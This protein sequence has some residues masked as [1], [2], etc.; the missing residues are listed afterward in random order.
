[1]RALLLH[2]L[3]NF[4][5]RPSVQWASVRPRVIVVGTH[6]FGIAH[7]IAR[8]PSEE[9]R[10]EGG[11]AS[12]RASE[13]QMSRTLLPSC[14]RTGDRTVDSLIGRSAGRPAG[15]CLEYES[16]KMHRE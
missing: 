4:S 1:M 15:W 7:A 11:R 10:R 16:K 5:G 13:Q 2:F 14:H 3:R 9:G 6:S 8:W 12:E